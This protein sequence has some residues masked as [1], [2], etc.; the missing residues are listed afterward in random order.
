[1]TQSMIIDKAQ[2]A[3]FADGELSPEDAA[4]VVMYLADHPEDQAYVDEVMAANLALVRAFAAPMQE[5]VPDRFTA[6]ILPAR[7]QSAATSASILAFPKAN[8]AS[9]ALAGLVSA[10][11]AIAATVTAIA[12]LPASELGLSVGPVA[13][14]AALHKILSIT[15]SGETVAFGAQSALTIL[16]SLPAETGYCRELEVVSTSAR[17]IQLGLAC[18]DGEGWTL[19]VVF[20]EV[21]PTDVISNGGYTPAS[22]DDAGAMDR[23]LDRRG[24]GTVMTPAQEAERIATG[25]AH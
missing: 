18:Q 13:R 8:R 7:R 1:M 4:A 14:T 24:A 10:G 20:A 16:S 12:V 3:A 6:L 19:D 11:L 17:L 22:G 2:L 23:W 9:L 25:W 15:P 21:L 5:P